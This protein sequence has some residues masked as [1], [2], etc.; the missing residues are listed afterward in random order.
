MDF[1][2]GMGQINPATGDLQGNTDQIIDCIREAI[3]DGSD[4]VA[5]PELAI[6]GYCCGAL[7]EFVLLVLLNLGKFTK[8]GL[9]IYITLVLLFRTRK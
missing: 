4:I 9:S 7:F 3:K 5:F 8:M 1:K 6:T 2:I